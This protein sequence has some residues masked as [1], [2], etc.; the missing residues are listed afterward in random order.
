MPVMFFFIII[1]IGFAFVG[2]FAFTALERGDLESVGTQLTILTAFAVCGLLVLGGGYGFAFHSTSSG[3]IV[4]MDKSG[5][6][7]GVECCTGGYAKVVLEDSPGADKVDSLVLTNADGEFVS[8]TEVRP[9]VRQARLDIDG[10]GLDEEAGSWHIAANDGDTVIGSA[11]YTVE[12]ER[13]IPFVP[14][15]QLVAASAGIGLLVGAA[16][17]W[18]RKRFVDTGEEVA[19]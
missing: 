1:T 14:I 6:I 19:A 8:E 17:I 7:S 11:S 10:S 12:M 15:E 13:G 16:A 5:V 4:E 2:A 9:N 18:H 3:E